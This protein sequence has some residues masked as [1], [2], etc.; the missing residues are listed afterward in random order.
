LKDNVKLRVGKVKTK[1]KLIQVD[2]VKPVELFYIYMCAVYY[3]AADIYR[4]R[5]THRG[6]RE[7]V[8][9]EN[10]EF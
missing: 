4:T 5:N 6:D 10:R 8:I 3:E 9:V 1:G 2:D 7:C